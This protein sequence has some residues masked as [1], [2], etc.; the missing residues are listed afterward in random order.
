MS[1]DLWPPDFYFVTEYLLFEWHGAKMPKTRIFY[2]IN[3]F[4]IF[5]LCVGEY[6]IIVQYHHRLLT[7][8]FCASLLKC[9]LPNCIFQLYICKLHILFQFDYMPSCNLFC[10]PY[11]LHYIFQNIQVFSLYVVDA[12]LSPYPSISHGI[13]YLHKTHQNPLWNYTFYSIFSPYYIY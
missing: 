12:S 9:V 7:N 13:S 2:L 3:S 11:V 4:N 8:Y 5:Y 6:R 10:L 1:P